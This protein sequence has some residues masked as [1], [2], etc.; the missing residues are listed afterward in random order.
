MRS[1]AASRLCEIRLPADEDGDGD[2]RNRQSAS[3]RDCCPRADGARRRCSDAHGALRHRN[4]RRNVRREV[5]TGRR[6]LR[7]GRENGPTQT[8]R[9][10]KHERSKAAKEEP[11]R[12]RTASSTG[13]RTLQRGRRRRSNV[14]K[15][16]ARAR[17]KAAETEDDATAERTRRCAQSDGKKRGAER[18]MRAE[19]VRGSPAACR[20]VTP[21]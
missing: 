13:Q 20:N 17:V 21:R 15:R 3:T 1:P 16:R 7:T 2:L 4:N 12:R 14:T 5:I 6:A 8:T 11:V 9:E 10:Q 19:H 18:R